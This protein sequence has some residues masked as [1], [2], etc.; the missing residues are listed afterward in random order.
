MRVPF[1]QYS[2]LFFPSLFA[3]LRDGIDPNKIRISQIAW[4]CQF[5]EVSLRP[6]D[7]CLLW[8][9]EWRVWPS[10]ENWYLYYRLRQ[11][12]RDHQLIE[13]AS[14]HLFLDYEASDLISFLQVG[15]I[16]GMDMHLIPTVSYGRVFISHDEW[17]EFA[18]QDALELDNIKADLVKAGSV[19]FEPDS[20]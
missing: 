17:V 15:L 3:Q 20:S 18:M 4:F 7:R 13:E 14:G 9:T 11:S 6:R 10:S 2:R 8:V 19:T 16:A 1:S 12:Y 5:I